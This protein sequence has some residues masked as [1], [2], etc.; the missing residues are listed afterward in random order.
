MKIRMTTMAKLTMVMMMLMKDGELVM[1]MTTW[2]RLSS[3][4]LAAM[5]ILMRMMTVIM[6]I[7]DNDHNDDGDSRL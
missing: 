1:T 2:Y 6:T 5:T 7:I 3:I 4:L